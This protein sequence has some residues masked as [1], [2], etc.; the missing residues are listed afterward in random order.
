VREVIQY[1]VGAAK[2][3]RQACCSLANDTLGGSFSVEVCRPRIIL[4]KQIHPGKPIVRESG[5]KSV[6]TLKTMLSF[7]DRSEKVNIK[8][9]TL[10]SV[11]FVNGAFNENEVISP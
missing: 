10:T 3:Y 2:V 5:G 7:I 11:C 9:R 1:V 4:N 6:L 8:L